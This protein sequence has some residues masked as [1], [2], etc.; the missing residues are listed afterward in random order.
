VMKRLLNIDIAE[1][2]LDVPYLKMI[3]RPAVDSDGSLIFEL[4]APESL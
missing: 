3:L 1:L 2:E 4:L